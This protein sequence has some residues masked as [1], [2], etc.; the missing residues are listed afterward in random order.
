MQ[1]QEIPEESIPDIHEASPIPFYPYL[2]EKYGL[3]IREALLYGF[4]SFWLSNQPEKCLFSTNK[5][6]AGVVAS[7]ESTISL[8]LTNLARKN[9]IKILFK[10]QGN[11]R[12][13]YLNPDEYSIHPW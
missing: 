8:A 12:E 1:K 6:L 3:S 7:N 4:V 11:V 5:E 9:L 2:V 10:Q 13:I